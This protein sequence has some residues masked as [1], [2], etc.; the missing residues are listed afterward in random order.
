MNIMKLRQSHYQTTLILP[1]VNVVAIV[2]M[3]VYT[4][5]ALLLTWSHM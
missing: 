1:L 5:G 4:I 3:N 2:M